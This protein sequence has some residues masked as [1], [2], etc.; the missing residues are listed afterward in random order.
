MVKRSTEMI[1]AILAVLKAGGAY[2]PIDPSYPKERIEYMLDSSKAKTLLTKKN[3]D[4]K[5]EFENK[6]LIDLSNKNI[7]SLPKENLDSI[8]KPEDLAYVIFTSGSTGK[9][10]GVMLMHKNINNF[11][12]GIMKKLEFSS[13]QTMVSITTISFDI[14]VLESLLPLQNGLKI[15]IANEQEQTSAKLF[16]ELC[17]KNNVDIIQTTPSRMQIFMTSEEDAEFIQKAKYILI[18]GEPFPSVLLE[19]LKKMSSAKIYNMYGPTETAVWSTV[20]ELTNEE[21]IDIGKPIAN[22]QVYVLDK[23]HKPLPYGVSGELYISGDG[24]SKGYLNREDLTK[25]CFIKNP[26]V[27]NTIMYKTGDLCAL[28]E[29]GNI[30]CLGRIDNQIKIRGLRIE[31]GEIETLIQKYPHIIKTVAVKQKIEDREFISAYFVSDKRIAISELRKYITHSLPKY[32]VPSYF[33]ALDEFPYTPNGKV[34]KKALPLPN[35]LLNVSKE[36]YVAPKTKL[37]KELAKTWEKVLNTSPI[38]I[39]D[40]FF[41]LGGDSLLAMNLNIELLK[42]SDRISYSDI[43]RFPTIAELAEKINSNSYEPIFSK[44]ENLSDDYVDILENCTKREKIVEWHPRNVLLTGCTGFLGIHILEQFIEKEEG[45]IYC[46]VR[47]EPGLT[48][49][50]K[51]KQKLNYYFENKYDDLIDKRIFAVI[52]SISKSGFGLNQ[53][54]LLDLAEKVDVVINSAARVAHFGN[55]QDFYNSNV[56][57]V[58]YM[59][60]FCNSF[61][62]KLYHISTMSIGDTKLDTEYLSFKKTKRKNMIFDETCLYKGQTLDNVYIRSKFEAES[63]ILEAISK[64]LDGYILRMGNL[65]PRYNDGVFQENILD[66]AFFNKFVAFI[67]LGVVPEYFLKQLLDFTPVDYA[68]EATYKLITH[69]TNENRIFHIYNYKTTTVNK[70]FKVLKKLGF[71]AE[72]LNE[73]DF[74]NK[75]NEILQDDDTKNILNNLIN[76]FNRDL[77]LDY[78]IDIILRS[79]FSIKYLRKIHFKWPKITNKYLTKFI[80]L[81]KGVI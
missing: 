54:E 66:N 29:N 44:I 4:R 72:V 78:K 38:G 69:P 65:M 67:K 62:K 28:L 70:C 71:K 40:N 34:D 55:Y 9:P 25:E 46:I 11:I 31:L 61:H 13:N 59:I 6:I 51:L 53:E 17:I 43:F 45:N 15:V 75:I 68:A 24:V 57:S 27:P 7:Y 49:N 58:K 76:D 56:K 16:N 81:I 18:G 77:H 12:K 73:N 42:L 74:K 5:I 26:F 20:K 39:N 21:T 3:L 22:T 63:L 35:E 37:E 48:A 79:K 2:I 1:I 32:M 30:K 19:S 60:D 36:K 50:A 33:I 23:N 41:E 8:N 64:G 10:K 52:G 14:F 80:K 47:E